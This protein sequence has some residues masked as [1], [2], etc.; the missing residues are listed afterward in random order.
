MSS[1]CVVRSIRSETILI[2][3]LFWSSFSFFDQDR[4]GDRCISIH[5][6]G[7]TGLFP[8]HWLSAIRGSRISLDLVRT[9]FMA[10]F[11]L[12][13]FLTS[14]YIP[15]RSQFF[16]KH[17]VLN[18]WPKG[19][20][21]SISIFD[22][23]LAYFPFKHKIL[24]IILHTKPPIVMFL[25]SKTS[26]KNFLTGFFKPKFNFYAVKHLVTLYIQKH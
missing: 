8:S 15:A 6:F 9:H 20:S 11:V 16:V 4:T 24:H 23:D 3:H 1:C 12:F 25:S 10:R 22:A 5:F 19:G 14:V 26:I 18:S 7:A 17:L 13:H 21:T 2:S